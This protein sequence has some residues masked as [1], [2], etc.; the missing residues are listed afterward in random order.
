MGLI[1]NRAEE[2]LI[3]NAATGNVAKLLQFLRSGGNAS[4][5]DNNGITP[6]HYAAMN[7][8]INVIKVLSDHNQRSY[9]PCT[10]QEGASDGSIPLHFAAYYG[11]WQ[12]VSKVVG[13][14]LSNI[15]KQQAERKIRDEANLVETT[16]KLLLLKSNLDTTRKDLKAYEDESKLMHDEMQKIEDDILEIDAGTAMKTLEDMAV[17]A[18][19]AYEEGRNQKLSL[20]KTTNHWKPISK[21]KFETYSEELKH[22]SE[23]LSLLLS[24]YQE[25]QTNHENRKKSILLEKREKLRRKIVLKKKV[26]EVEETL[27]KCTESYDVSCKMQEELTTQMEELQ[28]SI[29]DRSRLLTLNSRDLI[30]EAEIN[31][32]IHKKA[33]DGSTPL[34]WAACCSRS[35]TVKVLLEMAANPN[36]QDLQGM[37]ALHWACR[38]A[39]MVELPQAE[40]VNLEKR[41]EVVHFLL[42]HGANPNVQD[43]D[44]NTAL[45]LAAEIGDF[46]VVQQLLDHR[47]D[48]CI[49][50]RFKSTAAHHAMQNGSLEIGLP[51]SD[52]KLMNFDGRVCSTGAG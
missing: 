21:A 28:Q 7:N 1:M 6:C 9:V 15:R 36:Q 38:S 45:H 26:E 40:I 31:S 10:L 13:L 34:H 27:R 32:R 4:C 11:K 48:A 2:Q 41:I 23:R 35:Q 52:T 22:S 16:Q 46:D 30:S 47:A 18:K 51:P 20:E 8:Q 17:H 39:R 14:H 24:N 12:T 42:Q 49:S 25:A 29:R 19:V 3:F 43:V 44:G 33:N 5:Q 50:N 37:T